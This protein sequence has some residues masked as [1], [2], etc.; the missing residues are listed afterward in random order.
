MD[1]FYSISS[2]FWDL[3][4]KKNYEIFNFYSKCHVFGEPSKIH[5]AVKCKR[6]KFKTDSKKL[7]HR[8]FYLSSCYARFLIE[9]ASYFNLTKLAIHLVKSVKFQKD[10]STPK[11]L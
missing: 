6:L 9:A 3:K 10:D 2:D 4:K 8:N 7:N 11:S 5:L 1:I